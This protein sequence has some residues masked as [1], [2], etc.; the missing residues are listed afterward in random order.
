MTFPPYCPFT[1]QQISQFSAEEISRYCDIYPDMAVKLQDAL[2]A[3]F[4]E[5]EQMRE[6]LGGVERRCEES[7]DDGYHEAEKEVACLEVKIE[8]LEESLEA[9]EDQIQKAIKFIK[10]REFTTS[11]TSLLALTSILEEGLNL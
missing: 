1:E 10:S 4:S 2:G 11:E 7:W 8:N 3:A 6:E 9:K 5:I